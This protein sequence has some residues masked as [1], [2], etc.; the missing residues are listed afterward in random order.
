M[1]EKDLIIDTCWSPNDPVVGAH[2]GIQ[3]RHRPSKIVV[4][5]VKMKTQH[6]NRLEAMEKL[7]LELVKERFCNIDENELVDGEQ[8]FRE[9]DSGKSD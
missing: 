4:K 9:L 6:E 2:I 1:N 5:S 7:K 8:F 3:I